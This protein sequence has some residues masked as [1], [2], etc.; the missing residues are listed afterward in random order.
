[1]KLFLLRGIAVLLWSA[2]IFE[3]F[4]GTFIWREPLRIAG[5]ADGTT[6]YRFSL[7]RLP[8]PPKGPPYCDQLTVTKLSF[9]MPCDFRP[10]FIDLAKKYL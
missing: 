3:I 8:P 10:P 9:A 5:R 2:A 4:G 1:M 6:D 7:Y